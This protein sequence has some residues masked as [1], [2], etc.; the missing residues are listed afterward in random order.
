VIAWNGQIVSVGQLEQILRFELD[1][2]TLV[3]MF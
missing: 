1:P 3:P 2:L